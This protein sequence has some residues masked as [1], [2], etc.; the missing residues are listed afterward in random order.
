MSNYQNYLKEKERV[1]REIKSYYE[2]ITAKPTAWAG[3]GKFA[4]TLQYTIKPKIIVD[5]GVDYGFSTFLFGM[6]KIGKVYGVDT[7]AGDEHAG[8]HPDAEE[9]VQSVLK[10]IRRRFK[11]NSIEI[12]KSTFDEAAA[13]WDKGKINI[14][15]ID[16]LHT[17]EAVKN[18]YE[19]WL[20]HMDADGVVL[21]HDVTSFPDDVGKFFAELPTDKKYAFEHSAGLGVLALSDHSWQKI[22]SLYSVTN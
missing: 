17:Y 1:E 10:Q 9:F 22:K 12:I 7:F 8:S 3:H 15:H 11:N 4:L 16:G 13:N 19:K 6:L 18:D 2:L 20:P 5:L 14:L 21:F